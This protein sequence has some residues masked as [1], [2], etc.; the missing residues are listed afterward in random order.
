[1]DILKEFESDSSPEKQFV[2]VAHAVFRI[3]DLDGNGN[4]D[5]SELTKTFSEV[6]LA[7]FEMAVGL[8]RELQ[9]ILTGEPLERIIDQFIEMMTNEGEW[10]ESG[11][12]IKQIITVLNSGFSGED[13]VGLFDFITQAID[14]PEDQ[15][16]EM[17]EQLN[18]IWSEFKNILAIISHQYGEFFTKARK[19]SKD[20][21]LI[22]SELVQL[23]GECINQIFDSVQLT[24]VKLETT[25]LDL[26]MTGINGVLSEI[27]DNNAFKFVSI[28]RALIQ[29]IIST[30]MHSLHTGLRET[31]VKGYF[32]ALF[33]LFDLKNTGSIRVTD[34]DALGNM[35]NAVFVDKDTSN[36]KEKVEQ[37]QE[38]VF[39]L[40]AMLDTDGDATLGKSE[41]IACCKEIAE[42]VFTWI[43]VS[44][45][46]VEHTLVASIIPVSNM[47]LKIKSQILGGNS[48][49]LTHADV[50]S[51]IL[52]V[53]M[54]E[55]SSPEIIGHLKSLLV[56][57][58]GEV[59]AAV[60][61]NLCS[62]IVQIFFF[63]AP[64]ARETSKEWL[65]SVNLY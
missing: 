1:L 23:A 65:R 47:L 43:K 58:D 36:V 6:I 24:G 59:D 44:V 53:S 37:I 26:I 5:A 39:K 49:S 62:N 9:N 2:S 55:N 29:N 25:I 20:K 60:F 21:L 34:L 18:K 56:Y 40:I 52:A 31:G 4:I 19:I 35:V 32:N 64:E 45:Q 17:G 33:N 50:C 28:D 16:G 14:N 48:S 63:W 15:F 38:A 13:L 7:V 22:K 46:M 30:A 10:K 42:L 57:K 3:L 54:M 51:A 12:P 8:M 27:E 11:M 61:E 41:I